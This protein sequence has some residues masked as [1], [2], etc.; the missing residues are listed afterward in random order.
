[1]SGVGDLQLRQ[2]A[3]MRVDRRGEGPQS[4]RSLGWGQP[5]PVALSHDRSRHRV[6]DPGLVGLLD[7]AQHFLGGGVDDF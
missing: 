6:V 1:M 2:L 4:G 3:H 5:S 7:G